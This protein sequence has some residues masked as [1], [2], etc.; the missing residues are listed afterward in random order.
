M[1][2]TSTGENSHVRVWTP[3]APVPLVGEPTIMWCE[4]I[5][6]SFAPGSNDSAADS[7]SDEQ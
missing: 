7:G 3:P 1:T 4:R 5:L 2:N 6:S